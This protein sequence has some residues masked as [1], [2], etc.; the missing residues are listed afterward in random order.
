M[1]QNSP[2]PSQVSPFETAD[3]DA[4]VL[5]KTK[6]KTKTKKQVEHGRR[7][8]LNFEFHISNANQVAL[9]RIVLL[10][11]LARRHDGNQPADAELF[12]A[13]WSNGLLTRPQFQRFRTVAQNLA[14][15]DFSAFLP[16]EFSFSDTIDLGA[17]TRIWAAWAT[18]DD[19]PSASKTQEIRFDSLSSLVNNSTA[20]NEAGSVKGMEHIIW[21]KA[22]KRAYL[23]LL[24]A[25]PFP[26]PDKTVRSAVVKELQLQRLS[27]MSQS[28]EFDFRSAT[29]HQL[30]SAYVP[31]PSLLDPL[32]WNC[33]V[34]VTSSPYNSFAPL[35]PPLRSHSLYRTCIR[36]LE[37]Q[38][39]EFRDCA[40]LGR[41]RFSFHGGDPLVLALHHLPRHLRQSGKE[42]ALHSGVMGERMRSMKFDVIHTGSMV[43]STGVLNLLLTCRHLLYP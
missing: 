39:Q 22:Q 38:L 10:L 42:G 2:F 21:I 16:S 40:A 43:N 37:K 3:E 27:G 5:E 15:L 12:F 6:T 1:E 28:T 23:F 26:F 20:G 13:V 17:L 7:E 34:P 29:P 30:D 25:F 36:I 19:L 11:S 4:D 8:H 31:N 9:A 32:S 18:C 33:R 24:E 41:L 35:A 14:D